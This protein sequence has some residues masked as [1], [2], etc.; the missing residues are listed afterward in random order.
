MQCLVLEY[1][2]GGEFP[3]FTKAHRGATVDLMAE[4][5]ATHDE[6]YHPSLLVLIRNAPWPA[7]QALVADLEVRRRPVTTLRVEPAEELWFGR[8][9][10][11][12]ATLTNPGTQ[13]VVGLLGLLGPPWVHVE[14]G[15]VHLRARLLDPAQAEDVLN[16]AIEG[17]RA[18]GVEAQ[19]VVQEIA[20]KDHSVWESLVRHSIGL[21]L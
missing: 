10:Y 18:A 2:S 17:L 3:P 21:D 14:A 13:V 4:P 6:P 7:I 9:T 12:V 16:L 8:A 19:V 20:A 5:G 15:V 1:E 11:D